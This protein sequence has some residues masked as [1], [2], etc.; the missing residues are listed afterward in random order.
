MS[1]GGADLKLYN[2]RNLTLLSYLLYISIDLIL[3]FFCDT[4]VD[5]GSSEI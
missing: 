2:P 3:Q 1:L 4:S 5:P